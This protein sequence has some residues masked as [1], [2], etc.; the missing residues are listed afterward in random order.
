MNWPHPVEWQEE[1]FT[2]L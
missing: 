2:E 1:E